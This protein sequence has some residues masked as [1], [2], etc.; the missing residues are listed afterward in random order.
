M[1]DSSTARNWI[2]LRHDL[3]EQ[4]QSH[5]KALLGESSAG[6][7]KYQREYEKEFRK[8]WKVSSREALLEAI[9]KARI[10]WMGDFHALQQSQKAQLRVLKAA[11]HKDR[12]MIGME[13]I[14]ARHQKALDSYMAGKM[15][16]R[17][18]LKAI[19]WK[20]NWGF[21][22][23]HYRPIFRWAQ[24]NKIR[25]FGLNLKTRDRAA[26]ALKERDR[27]SGQKILEIA[28][29]FPQ[30]KLFVIYG[31]LHLAPR[32]LPQIVKK[33]ISENK[34]LYLY[35]NSERIYFQL[36]KKEIE[37]QVDVVKL[38][39]NSFCLLSV[40]PWVKWQNY[41]LYLESHYDRGVDEELDLMDYVAG[42]M[43]VIGHDLGIPV[44]TDHFSVLTASDRAGWQ[45]I[46]SEMTER[47]LEM[48]ESWVEDGR[49][50]FIPKTRIGFLGRP[51]VN[52]AAQLAMAIVF[53]DHSHQKRLPLQMPQD[54]SRLIWMEA[55]Q[56]LGSKLINPKRKTDT[57]N[58]IKATLQ[59][60]SPLDRGK[61]ALQLALN[62]KML[63]LLHLSGGRK[64]R[65]LPKPRKK[66]AYQEAARIL[67]GMLGEKLYH[68]YRRKLLSKTTLNSLLKKSLDSDEFSNIYL[69][70][71]ELIESFPEPFQSKA[72]KM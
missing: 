26:K 53:A 69:E 9:E 15:S 55:V 38:S 2:R 10:I 30:K 25:V 42:Y 27:F 12:W 11:A 35:Q 39:A 1:L 50:F 3:F 18:F 17:D 22:W 63:E 28:R 41:L 29:K 48:L 65:E 36:L 59:A 37:H 4:V 72:E 52:S 60:R 45:K 57:L 33:E 16:E 34:F 58:D 20:R 21:P 8:S 31:D 7:A 49:S 13:C 32:H 6:L 44:K 19:E 40:P 66:K 5:V 64:G 54:F 43:K 24:K 46:Q 51:S 68:A 47:E 56:Y 71:L 23:D 70:I 14:E 67:G 61:E 62:Q